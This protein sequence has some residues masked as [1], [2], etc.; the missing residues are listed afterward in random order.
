MYWLCFLKTD[1]FVAKQHR[2]LVKYRL[3]TNTHTHTHR[4]NLVMGYCIPATVYPLLYTR[5]C[6]PAT[7]YPLMYTRYCIPATVYPLLYT[8]YC[9]PATV[10]PL[11][12]TRYCIPATVYPLLYTRYSTAYHIPHIN[13]YT[14][15]LVN[16]V[17]RNADIWFAI[18]FYVLDAQPFPQPPPEYHGIFYV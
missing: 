2:V 9:I 15:R 4:A 8:R 14:N 7:L 17:F 11:L 3:H 6:I 18:S 12:Y 10:D 13:S 1:R 16:F 5:Y